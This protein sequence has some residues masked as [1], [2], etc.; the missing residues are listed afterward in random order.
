MKFISVYLFLFLCFFSYSQ[1]NK[2]K[3]LDVLIM[4]KGDSIPYESID[5]KEITVFPSIEFKNIEDKIKYYIIKRKT[6]KVYPY[7]ILASKRLTEL[8]KR[9]P[10]I[11][12][13]ARKKKYT[14]IVER[15]IEKEFSD[16]LKK[17]TRTEGQILIK[18]VHRETGETVYRLIKKLR[19]GFRAFSYSSLAKLF[20]ISLKE[21]YDPINIVEDVMIEDVIK[22]AYADKSI[23][24]SLKK[25]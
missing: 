12:N 9:L 23:K 14:K 16:E 10:L 17:L 4:I 13:R 6:L 18:L 20:N 5:L 24:L 3:D 2:Y 7:A 8:N 22:R 1:E 15:Y 19:N 25:K 11:K 21:A